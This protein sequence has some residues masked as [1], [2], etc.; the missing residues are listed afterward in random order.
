VALASNTTGNN[1]VAS[2]FSALSLN[3]TGPNNTAL[4]YYALLR[5]TTGSSNIAVGYGAGQNLTTG[6]NNIDI[7]N[8]GVAGESK[9][10]RIGFPGR[11]GQVATY[12][13]GI[14]GATVPAGVPVIID[15]TGHL[16]TTTSSA[17]YKDNIKP[18][19]KASEGIHALKPV[20]FRYKKELDPDGTAQFGLIAE[21][22]AKV[23]A[24]LV[25]RDEEGKPYTVRYEAVNAM[26]LNEFL[27]ERSKG[28][29]QDETIAQLE[30]AV[31]KHEATIVQQQKDF[32]STIAQQQKEIEALTASLKEQ[33]TQIEKVSDQVEL[34]K[35]ASKLV[36]NNQ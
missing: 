23:N 30:S 14:S 29:E 4:G 8:A 31:A 6:N 7:G 3:T 36:V 22:V 26:L 24:E 25:V 1:N 28:L 16:G 2:G 9:T 12:I 35:T 5:N 10:I 11:T 15:S 17:R 20:T 32:R 27:K 21:E 19:D 33:A 34:S 13:A 18:M